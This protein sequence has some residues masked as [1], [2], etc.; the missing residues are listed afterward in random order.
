MLKGLFLTCS[1]CATQCCTNRSTEY[2]TV[3]YPHEVVEAIQGGAILEYNKEGDRT[4]AYN[5]GTCHMWKD[6]R[7][8]N[9]DIWRAAV[10]KAYPFF[11]LD[12]NFIVNNRCP[13]SDK[14]ASLD[15]EER[16][17]LIKELSEYYKKMF[18]PESRKCLLE[19]A[20]GYE[21]VQII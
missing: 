16:Y 5:D 1:E 18:S 14:V 12:G 7:C 3:V 9:H 8:S 19:I 10:C 11:E 21:E 2:Q 17:I 15:A 13:I 6:G 4:L 20:K